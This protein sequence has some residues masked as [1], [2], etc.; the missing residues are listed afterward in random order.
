MVCG[1]S[2]R[3]VIRNNKLDIYTIC[4]PH[5]H[6]YFLTI[7]TF[8]TYYN[9]HIMHTVMM[10]N[11]ARWAV[12]NLSMYELYSRYALRYIVFLYHFLSFFIWYLF[13]E[14]ILENDCHCANLL[15]FCKD[16][17]IELHIKPQDLLC[18]NVYVGI[19]MPT[20]LFH[21]FHY[22]NIY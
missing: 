18:R 3:R 16:P 6:S 11:L 9:A 1:Q 12:C 21:L 15:T 20:C 14:R 8:R 4:I 10:T 13:C 22:E 7:S 2:I 19:K 5:P 17:S